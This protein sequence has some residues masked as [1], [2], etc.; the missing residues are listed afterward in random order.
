MSTMESEY[1]TQ[2]VSHAYHV[3][4]EV[5]DSLV[6]ELEYII[7][8]K[9][10]QT[11]FQP[12][13]DLNN[14]RVFGYEAL[15]RGP[16]TSSLH[17]PEELFG[18][19]REHHQLFA[20]ECVCR[21][22]AIEK[23]SQMDTEERLFLNVEPITLMDPAFRKGATMKILQQTGLPPSRVVIELTEHT[24][25]W[26][27]DGLKRAVTH[28]RDM[29]F[30]IALDDLSSGYS[31]LQLMAELRPEYLKLDIYF[32][33]KLA[34]DRVA[35]EFAR[36]IAG[37]AGHIGCD[38]IA[39]GIESM[40]VLREVNNLGLNFAQGYLL[41]RPSI[42]PNH[43]IPE[44]IDISALRRMDKSREQS[45]TISLLSQRAMTCSPVDVPDTLLRWFHKDA[46]LLAVPVIEH[47]RVVGMIR[48]EVLLGRF[49][50]PFGRE[51]YAR[52]PVSNL[53]WKDP[54]IVSAD[55][56]IEA[57]SALVTNRAHKHMYTPI[58][59]EDESGYAGMVFVHDLLEYI[60]K[61]RIEQ[62]MNANP[63]TH[64]PGNID[65]EQE[66]SRRLELED[67]FVL[68]YVDLDNFKAFNDCYGYER[69]DVML[70]MLADIIKAILFDGSI[71]Y[72]DFAGHIGGDD[73]I[74]LLEQ[75]DI[76]EASLHTIIQAFNEQSHTLYDVIDAENGYITAKSR[77]G[78]TRKFPLASLSIGATL[79]SPGRFVSHL[80]A[81]EVASE[82]KCKAKKTVGNH[83]EIDRRIHPSTDNSLGLVS[84]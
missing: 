14:N 35:R 59:V 45:G 36:A 83:L 57:V 39:E 55:A 51:L 69:G 29:G 41:G 52:K 15:S 19:A 50:M 32:T 66:V 46:S 72:R 30:A 34:D 24:Q 9:Q 26:D 63:L 48:R 1:A 13:F 61:N 56:P 4:P 79:C 81:A 80:E 58:I 22:V 7:Q 71:S 11:L 28:Y 84:A 65:I 20:L 77:A 8:E 42:N 21:E 2:Q 43:S 70:R 76:W 68:C 27:M 16:D 82:L 73:F 5:E 33:R 64:L 17:M 25:V 18:A 3:M 10:I 78:R 6:D 44:N 62:A 54:L 49:A 47:G 23:F 38:V 40:D 12:I 37:L 74:I 53:M 31:N 60:T 75:R 67:A